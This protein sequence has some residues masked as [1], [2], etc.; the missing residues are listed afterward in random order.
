M[1]RTEYCVPCWKEPDKISNHASFQK[2]RS[3]TS[4]R[5]YALSW[6]RSGGSVEGFLLEARRRAD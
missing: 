6:E 3:Q 2:S 5:S 1:A 4:F